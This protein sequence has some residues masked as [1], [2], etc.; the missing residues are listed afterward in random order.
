MLCVGVYLLGR[1]ATHGVKRKLRCNS[2]RGYLEKVKDMRPALHCHTVISQMIDSWEVGSDR[3]S[4]GSES[5]NSLL[6]YLTE[7][8]HLGC[9]GSGLRLVDIQDD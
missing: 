2:V 9:S 6:S 5:M 7:L 4:Q 3:I 8:G 1:A